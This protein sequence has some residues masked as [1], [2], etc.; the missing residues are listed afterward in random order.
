[1]ATGIIPY[2]FCLSCFLFFDLLFAGRSF[3]GNRVNSL[4]VFFVLLSFF[5]KKVREG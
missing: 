1:M 2:W 3:N 4:L 5:Q